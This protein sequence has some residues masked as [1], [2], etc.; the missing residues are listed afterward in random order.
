MRKIV[1]T[2]NVY[3]FM[4]KTAG[5]RW[6]SVWELQKKSVRRLSGWN[7][8]EE[9]IFPDISV[10]VAVLIFRVS[11]LGDYRGRGL[12][13]DLAVG[14][15]QEGDGRTGYSPTHCPLPDLHQVPSKTPDSHTWR[16]KIECLPCSREIF[17]SILVGSLNTKADPPQS[18]A[19]AEAQR[20]KRRTAAESV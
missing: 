10:R 4:R 12:Y 3:N 1:L 2:L 5:R 15:A 19:T 17:R 18:S 13:I 6:K 8:V 16:L 14:D 7:Q 9:W 20:W 11:V